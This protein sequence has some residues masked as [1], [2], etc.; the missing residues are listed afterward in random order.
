VLDVADGQ[1][2]VIRTLTGLDWADGPAVNRTLI[3][4]AAG[5]A[6]VVIGVGLGQN[7]GAS[8]RDALAARPTPTVSV[9]VTATPLSVP[10]PLSVLAGQADAGALV[11]K[12]RLALPNTYG[13][14]FVSGAD[15]PLFG[16]DRATG[17]IDSFPGHYTD[18]GVQ[19]P[20]RYRLGVACAGIGV[21]RLYALLIVGSQ[22]GGR[23]VTCKPLPVA[24][25]VTVDSSGGAGLTVAILPDHIVFG[26]IAYRLER[27]SG[28]P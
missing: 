27:L 9:T 22:S 2:G 4:V 20:G 19:P 11:R 21:D 1:S 13:P 5:A 28:T 18:T 15:Q 25:F 14:S 12:A 8:E 24:Q 17:A 26:A 3:A 6:C 10:D 7:R 16:P 23:V